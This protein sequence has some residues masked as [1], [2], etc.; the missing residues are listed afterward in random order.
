MAQSLV[1]GVVER[2][3]EKSVPRQKWFGG[4]GR[5]GGR[6]AMRITKKKKQQ[7]EEV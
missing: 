7:T 1:Q 3:Y 4:N 6:P 2:K 5:V